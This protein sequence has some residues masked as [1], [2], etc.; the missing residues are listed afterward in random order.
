[1][2]TASIIRA[3]SKLHMKKQKNRGRLDQVETWPDQWMRGE[4]RGEDRQSEGA[5]GRVGG[6]KPSQRGRDGN[7]EADRKIQCVE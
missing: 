7:M 6:L 2:L 3:V 1:V 5:S 4:Y